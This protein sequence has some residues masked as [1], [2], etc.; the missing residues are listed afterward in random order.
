M[1]HIREPKSGGNES[2]RQTEVFQP[3]KP[4]STPRHADTEV[5]IESL[6]AQLVSSN[7]RSDGAANISSLDLSSSAPS[8]NLSQSIEQ[9]STQPKSFPLSDINDTIHGYAYAHQPP[10]VAT[11]LESL[12]RW[13]VPD[14]VYAEPRY[15]SKYTDA[16]DHPREYAGLFFDLT[17]GGTGP[18]VLPGWNQA[19]IG[20]RRHKPTL[21]ATGVTGWEFASVPPSVREARAWAINHKEDTSKKA[22]R[23]DDGSQVKETC[24]RW[25]LH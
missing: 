4:D 13:N 6:N 8:T 23:V 20:K 24:V 17:A 16:P 22:K 14:K 10:P 11:L 25:S 2:L 18:S 19:D 7:D 3:N 21:C 9:P 12:A 5:L 1:F 15:Y